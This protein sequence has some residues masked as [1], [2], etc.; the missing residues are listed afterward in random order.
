[1]F[2]RYRR[3]DTVVKMYLSPLAMAIATVLQGWG[4]EE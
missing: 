1:M 3:G 2:H 4:E